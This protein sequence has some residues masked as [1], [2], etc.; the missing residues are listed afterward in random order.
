M[1]LLKIA[2]VPPVVVTPQDSVKTA[3][4]KM[5]EMGVG[6]VVVVKDGDL[7]AFSPNAT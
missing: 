4:N 3:V 2:R 6:A 5:C 7:V 1:N